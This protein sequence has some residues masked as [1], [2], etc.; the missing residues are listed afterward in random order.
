MGQ[1][2]LWGG[3]DNTG[4]GV[5]PQK[6]SGPD[7]TGRE[8]YILDTANGSNSWVRMFADAPLTARREGAAIA[9]DPTTGEVYMF[10]G[11][12]ISR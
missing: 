10:G 3:N 6:I 5:F 8:V 4:P 11:R 2:L 1:G 9:Y 7:Y 12:T